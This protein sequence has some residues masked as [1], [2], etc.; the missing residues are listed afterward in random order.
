[1]NFESDYDF[2]V[3]INGEEFHVDWGNLTI[4]GE[5]YQITPADFAQIMFDLVKAEFIRRRKE[6]KQN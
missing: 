1:M 2:S 3:I 4:D 6:E 5:E